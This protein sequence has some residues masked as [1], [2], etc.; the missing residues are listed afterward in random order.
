MHLNT[1]SLFKKIDQCRIMFE[2]SNI[3]IITISET[4]LTKNIPTSS[5]QIQGYLSLRQDRSSA[6]TNKKRG[7]GLVT[8]IHETHKDLP[9]LSTSNKH[10][11]VL[12]TKLAMPNCRNM[13]VCNIYRPPGGKMAKCIEYLE[14]CRGSVNINKTD[15]IVLG[16]LNVD[17]ANK[18]TADYKKLSFFLKSNQLSQLIKMS[19]RITQ[20][21]ATT[22]DL[23][24]TN[25]RYIS[26]SGTIPAYLS[27]HQPVYLIKKKGR[28]SR[29]KISFQGRSYRNFNE[30]EFKGTLRNKEW[31]D[32]IDMSTL[33]S[34]WNSLY[35]EIKKELD[36]ICPIRKYTVRGRKP[37]WLDNDLIERIKDRDYFC[38]K[39]KR[40]HDEDDWNIAKR[41]RNVTNFNIRQVKVNFII[42]NLETNKK[43]RNSGE[44][45]FS[46]QG[47]AEQQE[48][49]P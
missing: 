6:G 25:C 36:L 37:K 45:C 21:T 23:A 34:A 22:L 10:C 39:A 14:L 47:S 42:N 16:D 5:I 7:G 20:K 1:R 48:C 17:F 49:Y 30:E 44:L 31:R 3:D 18:A 11:E 43:D 38:R 27:D 12:W 4:W 32:I 19:T 41:L 35:M 13:I 26:Q 8:L 9:D 24:I 28:D 2:A 46:R 40:T 29:S 33:E 15:V